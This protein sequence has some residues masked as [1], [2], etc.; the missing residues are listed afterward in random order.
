M[1]KKMIFF[2]FILALASCGQKDE[3]NSPTELSYVSITKQVAGQTPC[4]GCSI[5]D[6]EGNL[7]FLTYQPV[8]GETCSGSAIYDSQDPIVLPT[9]T[10]NKEVYNVQKLSGPNDANCF[11][12]N[13]N[14]EITAESDGVMPSR[15]E[16]FTGLDIYE[17][18]LSTGCN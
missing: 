1:M 10:G 13:I 9:R 6:Y 14:F 18:C 2:I 4:Q 15:I 11:P 8:D 17:M 12:D 5:L 16:F 3:N 7:F